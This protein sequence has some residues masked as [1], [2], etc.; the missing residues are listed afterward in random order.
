[1]RNKF[2]SLCDIVGNN[3]DVAS[4]AETKVNSLLLFIS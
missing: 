1:M 2:E 3:V 4:I